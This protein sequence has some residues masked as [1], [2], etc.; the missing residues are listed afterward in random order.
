VNT[1]D[2]SKLEES[3]NSIIAKIKDIDDTFIV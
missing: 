1:V 3:L 2:A